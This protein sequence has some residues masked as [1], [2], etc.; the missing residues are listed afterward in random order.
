MLNMKCLKEKCVVE[1]SSH[2]FA[3]LSCFTLLCFCCKAPQQLLNTYFKIYYIFRN[4]PR[5]RFKFFYMNLECQSQPFYD[6]FL[7]KL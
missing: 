6:E 4:E 5:R 1:L 3:C 7:N 2:C